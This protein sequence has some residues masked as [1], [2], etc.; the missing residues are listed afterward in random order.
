MLQQ[1]VYGL[2][3]SLNYGIVITAEGGVQRD[4]RSCKGVYL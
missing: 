3:L 2:S 1:L 4:D